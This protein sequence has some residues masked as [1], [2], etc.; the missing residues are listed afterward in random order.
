[1][2]AFTE[3]YSAEPSRD[4]TSHSKGEATTSNKYDPYAYNAE[5]DLHT[6]DPKQD[7]AYERQYEQQTYHVIPEVIKNFIQYFHKTVTD[8]IDQKVYELQ[9]NRVT[10]DLI[11]QKLYE[12]QDIYE[13]SWNKLTERFFKTSPWPEAEA[14]ASICRNDVVFLILYK[15][16]YYRH[17]YAKVSGGP[18]LEQRFES[19]YNYCNLFNYILNADGPVPLELPNQWL[20]DVIDEFIYQ[21]QSFSQYR[22][23]TAKKTDEEIE[24]LRSNP[25]IW[26]VHSVLN[27]LHSLVDKSNINQQLE[28]YTSGGDPE[29]V[30]GDYG[31][32]SLYK[33]LGYFSL[34]GL[35]RLHSLLGDYYQ[36]IKVLEN[37]ELNK[38]SMYSR[39]PECQVT[40][41]YYVGFAYLMMRRYQD[42]I[43]VFANILLYI[44]RTKNMFQ[45][46]TYKYEMINKQNEQMHSLLAIALTLYPMRIDE[47]IH[48]Q[49]REKYGDKMIRMQ[50]GDPQIFE[51]LFSF[52]CP[53]FLSPVVPNYDAVHAN[54][55]KEPFLQQLKVFMD[56][57]QQQSVLST[58]R[59]FL[60]LYT[61][62]PVAKLAGF[63]DMSEQEFRINLLVFK[64]KMKNLVWTSGVSALDGEF[65]SASEVDFYIDKDMIH[66]ADTK[67]ARRYGDFFIRQIHKF[68]EL[69]KSL[70][71]ISPR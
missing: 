61:T 37:I 2:S 35:L 5:Y 49:L 41:Y 50:K 19:Y 42:S 10:S 58:I 64:H 1:M 43:R 54:Y 63:L 29:S 14:I 26:N 62:M 56:E 27:V 70:K 33:M 57:V 39:V 3:E 47:S 52:A 23:K 67:V 6:G 8:L 40:T 44:Q 7:L 46:S 69:N 38:K 30:A 16:L 66:I 48:T 53:K 13:N 51:E 34:V 11:E 20:W 68:E 21:F 55:H 25:K 28:V 22:C 45:R 9:A 59:S 71:K 15:E 18:T 17:I 36:A 24:F 65:Q 12:I 32:H 60:K 4:D 31:R